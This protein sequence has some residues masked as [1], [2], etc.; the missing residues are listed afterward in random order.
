MGDFFWSIG[1]LAVALGMLVTVHEFG[2][3]FVAR[4]VGV[5]VLRFSVGFG[6]PLWRWQKSAESTEYVIA[7]VP[8]GGYVKMLGESDDP[9]D[10]EQRDQAFSAK[11]VG[12]RIAVVAA[13]PLANFLLAVV[14]FWCLY[15]VGVSGLKP[16]VGQIQFD[17][18][19]AQAGFRAGDQ[20]VSVGDVEVVLWEE[21]GLQLLSQAVDREMVVNFPIEWIF[22]VIR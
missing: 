13:G 10:A 21:V 19:A 20:I 16:I 7:A 6:K 2:H 11:T 1:G 8:L 9:V 22:P 17:S 5:R 12:Q 18:P 4:K 3:F 14:L 15:M